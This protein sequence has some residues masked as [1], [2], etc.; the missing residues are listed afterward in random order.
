MHH[1]QGVEL[2]VVT[3][4]KPRAGEVKETQASASRERQGIDHELGDRPL[5]D[6]ARFIVK[7]V[8]AAVADLQNIDVA[9]DR[10][11][12]VDRNVK[13][14]LLLHV[15]DVCAREIDRHFHCHGDGIRGE[16]EALEL[17]MPTLVVGDRLQRKVR[18]PWRKVLPL[19][20]LDA[21]E[22]E[23]I[24]GLRGAVLFLEECVRT[25]VAMSVRYVATG[26][27]A[28]CCFSARMRAS[29]P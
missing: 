25:G 18:N 24:S 7:H 16:H 19:H 21:G 22:V 5:V 26:L 23:R 6:G 3:V 2:E 20:D 13:A 15:R 1:V 9:G 10:G 12:S 14:K 4:I 27:K 17:V 28:S 8:D 11:S 29:L